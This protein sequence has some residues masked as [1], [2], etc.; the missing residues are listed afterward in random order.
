M[1]E[2]VRGGEEGELWS[3]EAIRNGANRISY[4]RTFWRM[5]TYGGSG[6]SEATWIEFTDPP[7]QAVLNVMADQQRLRQFIERLPMNINEMDPNGSFVKSGPGS[8]STRSKSGEGY[9]TY[10][11]LNP[12]QTR[13]A[14]TVKVDLPAGSYKVEWYDPKVGSVLSSTEITTSG[15]QVTLAYPEFTEDIVLQVLN[16]TVVQAMGYTG[17]FMIKDT[18]ETSKLN[19]QLIAT[20]KIIDSALHF[21]YLPILSHHGEC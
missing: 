9:V 11:L 20:K 13:Q 1:N 16:K 5:F 3:D 15:G 12:G 2:L 7:N 10:F 21:I 4:R 18:L 6:S 19:D 17:D 8:Y 14:G